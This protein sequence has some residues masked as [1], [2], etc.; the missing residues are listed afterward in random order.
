MSAHIKKIMVAT[1]ALLG[2][3]ALYANVS[4]TLRYVTPNQPDHIAFRWRDGSSVQDKLLVI[5]L[6][7]VADDG[8]EPPST[9]AAND[10]CSPGDGKS[11]NPSTPTS[12]GYDNESFKP[13]L[14]SNGIV[15]GLFESPGRMPR[16]ARFRC[17]SARHVKDAAYYGDGGEVTLQALPDRARNDSGSWTI[18]LVNPAYKKLMFDKLPTRQ[19]IPALSTGDTAC[20][21]VSGSVNTFPNGANNMLDNKIVMVYWRTNAVDLWKPLN[22][23]KI[24]D[25]G[26]FSGVCPA[27]MDLMVGMIIDPSAMPTSLLGQGPIVPMGGSGTPRAAAEPPTTHAARPSPTAV[28][29][30]RQ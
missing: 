30:R 17:F 15:I 28:P 19:D 2:V 29:V 13:Q 10:Y 14:L 1:M 7:D 22:E 18:S 21:V 20:V 25:E 23:F 27:V 26:D 3:C 16:K 11:I 4:G 5:G 9:N 12:I 24:Q 8:F 6:V